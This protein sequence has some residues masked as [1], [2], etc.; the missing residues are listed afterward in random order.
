MKQHG[1]I[2]KVTVSAYVELLSICRS[3]SSKLVLFSEQLVAVTL[4]A[5]TSQHSLPL[6]LLLAPLLNKASIMHTVKLVTS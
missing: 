1:V 3:V 4:D 6:M 5:Y 2:S